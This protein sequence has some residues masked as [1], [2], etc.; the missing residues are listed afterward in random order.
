MLLYH[1]FWSN[2]K[3]ICLYKRCY[4]IPYIFQINVNPSTSLFNRKIQIKVHT[5]WNYLL[6]Q[7][8]MSLQVSN[9]NF[10]N[11]FKSNLSWILIRFICSVRMIFLITKKKVKNYK[12]EIS[13]L[14]SALSEYTK[15]IIQPLKDAKVVIN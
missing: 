1:Q 10:T 2:F 12:L 8:K 13:I 15:P 5:R 6:N 3:C 4:S 7:I 14:F 9:L 11:T